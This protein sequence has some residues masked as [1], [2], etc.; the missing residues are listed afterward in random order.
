M[1]KITAC[2][3][4]S[5]CAVSAKAQNTIAD[6]LQNQLLPEVIVRAFEQNRGIKDVPAAVNYVGRQQLSRYNNTSVVS[7]LNATAGVRMEE[8]SPGSYRLNIRGSSLRSPFGVRN[9]KVYYNKIPFTDPGGNT[10]LNQLGFYNF[11]SIEVLKGPGSSLYG[12]GTGGVMLVESD[13]HKGE[14]GVTVDYAAGSFGLRNLHLTAFAGKET[15]KNILSFQHQESNGFRDHSA[16][17]R[18]V[19]TYE[20]NN[21]TSEN[22]K[23]TTTFLY[24]NLFYKTPG[25]LTTDE[26]SKNPKSARPRAGTSPG[27]AEAN[28]AIYQ[29]MIFAGL[30]NENLFTKNWKNVTSVY[31]AYTKMDN[32]A[33]RNFAR[34]NQ[35]H[36][37]G[38]SLFE[39]KKTL[40][41]GELNWVAGAELQQSFN[42]AK[43][44]KNRGGQTDSL[45][46]DD[47]INIQNYFVFSQAGYSIN[48][49]MFTAGL[50][51]NKSKLSFTRLSKVPATA[52]NINFG[53]QLAPRV[54]ALY[55][56]STEVS[57]FVSW[58]QGFSPPTA[59]ELFP[60]GSLVNPGLS[61]ERGNNFEVAIKGYALK[62]K[63]SFDIDGFYFRLNNAV[64]QRRDAFGGDF[65]TNAGS[66]RQTG[67]ESQLSWNVLSTYQKPQLVLWVSH[68]MY[69]FKYKDFKQ[70]TNDYSGNRLPGVPR[71]NVTAGIDFTPGNGF[72]VNIVNQY[73]G[74]VA[75]NDANTAYGKAF[76][77]LSAKAGYKL[78]YK[79]LLINFYGG[80]ENLTNASYSLGYDIN[81]FGGR[82]YNAAA[83]RNYYGGLSV[84][85]KR[86]MD[87]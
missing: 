55:K 80:A 45:Q 14:D 79:K 75:L 84:S 6:T 7:A 31:A 17:E 60:T 63:L 22:N 74:S 16:L 68:S 69:N 76:Y 37:G 36:V 30:S 38:R 23:L 21:Q 2:F 48:R 41:A 8:R 73:L 13:D 61:A 53:N 64:V 33:I 46:S 77:L 71:Q 59:D 65:Y 58:S 57:A 85:L 47:E 40:T 54:S 19:L 35:P 24:G 81:A 50:S 83:G 67:I 49:W 11:N 1:K 52:L 43:V 42:T 44:Y 10:Y 86:R 32:P 56:I 72:Y 78:A 5:I 87:K 82:Y 62:R 34:N 66:T 3:F 18:T 27:A 4:I 25:A 70:L 15:N 26:F 51:L 39:F 9:V 12:A 29:K 20:T 28:A